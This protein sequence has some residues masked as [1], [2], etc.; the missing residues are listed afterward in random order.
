MS[1]IDPEARQDAAEA[2]Q[3]LRTYIEVQEARRIG[4][5]SKQD[6]VNITLDKKLDEVKSWLKWAGSFLFT[7]LISLLLWSLAQ[8]YQANRAKQSDIEAVV[9]REDLRQEVNQLQEKQ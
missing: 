8:Q 6:L 9:E 4:F 7:S 2:I 1:A 3:A 5:E